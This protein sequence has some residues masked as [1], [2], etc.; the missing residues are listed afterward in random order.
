[1]EMLVS[2][3]TCVPLRD[4]DLSVNNLVPAAATASSYSSTALKGKQ[5]FRCLT[6][7]NQA[8]GDV[9]EMLVIDWLTA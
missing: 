7:G 8:T 6:K 3:A 2:L 1:M 9:V 4:R 5:R